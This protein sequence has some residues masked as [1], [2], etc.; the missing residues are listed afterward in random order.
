M[1]KCLFIIVLSAFLLMGYNSVQ[2][3]NSHKHDSKGMEQ[4]FDHFMLEQFNNKIH[5]ALGNY[6]K[7]DSIHFQFDWWAKN[8]D[9]VEMQQSEKG[10]ELS[11]PYLI[12]FTV[13]TYSEDGKHLGT[14]AITFGVTPVYKNMLKDNNLITMQVEQLNLEHQKPTTP[15]K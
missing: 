11:H 15:R 2:A 7:R 14:D 13:K 10:R 9:V 12:K 3:E 4:V 5:N 1:K 8:Y 6:Y